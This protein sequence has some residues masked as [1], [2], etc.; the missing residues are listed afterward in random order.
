M[1]PI[2]LPGLVLLVLALFAATLQAARAASDVRLDCQASG[3]SWNCNFVN[4]EQSASGD[5]SVPYKRVVVPVDLGPDFGELFYRIPP[6]NLKPSVAWKLDPER[7]L[8]DR[9]S[10]FRLAP[11]VRQQFD[12]ARLTGQEVIVPVDLDLAISLAP[13][14]LGLTRLAYQRLSDQARFAPGWR[15]G[16]RNAQS[17]DGRSKFFLRLKIRRHNGQLVAAYEPLSAPA[18]VKA[19]G[20]CGSTILRT[21]SE[22]LLIKDADGRARLLDNRRRLYFQCDRNGVLIAG[23]ETGARVWS[24]D[25]TDLRGVDVVSV[26]F[27][28]GGGN[29]VEIRDLLLGD[30]V[31]G[32]VRWRLVRSVAGYAIRRR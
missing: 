15:V 1:R 20:S 3:S 7:A 14:T 29:H 27:A 24:V 19:Q 10:N 28:K 9:S 2:E 32:E 22:L 26:R 16:D 6:G 12:S 11:L 30:Y 13:A 5:R 23:P 18:H 31:T 8:G 21:G 17:V 4:K 25:A